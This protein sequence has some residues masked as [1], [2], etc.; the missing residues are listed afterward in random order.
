MNNKPLPP[1]AQYKMYIL[2]RIILWTIRAAML[3]IYLHRAM[4][5]LSGE[6][7]ICD[8]CWAYERLTPEE[9]RELWTM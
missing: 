3:K 5:K 7:C 1:E 2:V 8:K 9:R 6:K 4:I